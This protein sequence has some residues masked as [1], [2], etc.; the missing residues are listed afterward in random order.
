[1]AAGSRRRSDRPVPA[2]RRRKCRA[3]AR[4]SSPPASSTSARRRSREAAGRRLP[5]VD[6][7]AQGRFE[8]PLRHDDVEGDIEGDEHGEC[9]QEGG[10]QRLPQGNAPDDPH[11]ARDQEKA[12]DIEPEPLREQAEHQRG[13]EDLHDAAQLV[14]REEYVRGSYACRERGDETVEA[15]GGED[16]PEIEREVAGLRSVRFPCDPGAP[17]VEAEQT[18]QREQQQRD[19]DLDG[20]GADHGWRIV[21][22]RGR[23]LDDDFSFG[24]GHEWTWTG[25]TASLAPGVLSLALSPPGTGL[26]AAATERMG[27]GSDRSVSL[28]TPHPNPFPKREEGAHRVCRAF[29]HPTSDAVLLVSDESG[30]GHE[31]LVQRV[32]LFQELH[33]V[34][35]GEEDGLERLLI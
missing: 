29:M 14:A 12:C 10:E 3:R 5:S 23:S 24:R 2:A 6:L 16:E 30:F 22:R 32:V 33:H 13:N 1:M 21:R 25:F 15:G 18:R 34:L 28:V 19:D 26:L 17:V 4:P 11:E 35:A 20:A 27:A 9:E 31:V 8:R 7:V